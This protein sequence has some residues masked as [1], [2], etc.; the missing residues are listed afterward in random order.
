MELLY[1]F[2]V[3]SWRIPWY[4]SV[5]DFFLPLYSKQFESKLVNYLQSSHLLKSQCS[6]GP[7]VAVPSL[8]IFAPYETF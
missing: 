8:W 5:F 4:N 7:H 1:T 3:R 2:W 6:V